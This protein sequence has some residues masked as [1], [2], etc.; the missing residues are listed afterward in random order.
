MS[1]GAR[2]AGEELAALHA[3]GRLAERYPEVRG[4]LAALDE[5]TGEWPPAALRRAGT[6]LARLGHEAVLAEHPD[7]PCVTVGITG[8]FTL[9]TLVAPLTAQLARH[10][11]L[12]RPHLTG[13]G[14]F[15]LQLS[16]PSSELYRAAPEVT[17]CVLDADVVFGR[18]PPPWTAADVAAAA[19]E[20]AALVEELAGVQGTGRLVLNTVPLPRER[21]AQLVD[22]RSRTELAIAWRAFNTRLLELGLRDPH[23][24]VIDLEP[25]LGSVPRLNDPRTAAY[26]GTA[27]SDELLASYAREVGH[28]VR[29]MRGQTAKCLV[30]DL[31]GTLWDGILAEDGPAGI[32]MA[33]GYRGAAY[34][35]FQRVVKQLAAQG[36]LLA[37]CSKNDDSAVREALRDHPDLLLR[38]D[39]FVSVSASWNPKPE[40]VAA[41]ARQIGIGVESLVFV[42]DNHAERGLVRMALPEVTVVAVDAAEPALHVERLLADGWFT[43]FEVTG[44]DRART[45]R[46]RAE[47]ARDGFRSQVS[48]AGDYLAGLGVRVAVT[49]P[50]PADIA[51][52]AQ[53]T[54]RTN[55]FNLTTERLDPAAV[56]RRAADPDGLVLAVRSADRFGEDG[57]VGALFARWEGAALVVDN[58]V[59]SC[60]VLGR[61]IES[62]V[63]HELVA[64]AR[65]GGAR[66]VRGRFRPSPRNGKVRDLY[67]DHGFAP[68]TP[69]DDGE[70]A[71]EHDLTDHPHP[72]PHVTMDWRLEGQTDDRDG[73]PGPRTAGGRAVLQS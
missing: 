39:D 41:I 49:R 33:G 31:D 55:Q 1:E 34:Q 67:P 2:R 7:T 66:A 47:A 30:L 45:A 12:L 29:A 21:A 51:R 16:D 28:L 65:D 44:D 36:P 54:Q 61:G 40:G 71:Y 62:A 3:S 23:V 14:Q 20:V 10:G 59:L 53:L 19:G 38:P 15:A 50:G 72:A 68:V 24:T 22:H 32:T 42:D 46:Y 43:T 9:Q 60:R 64:H 70:A 57:L 5:E 4:L 69:R 26:A 48:S 63:L 25:L 58:M 8:S 27:M 52:V 6:V 13:H 73:I 37:V 17:L 18:V 56:A 11:L 35:S